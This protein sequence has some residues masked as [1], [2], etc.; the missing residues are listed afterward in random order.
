MH[1]VARMDA[2]IGGDEGESAA[3]GKGVAEPAVALHD[4]KNELRD[5]HRSLVGSV[6]RKTG[7]DHR[8]LMQNSS[9][10]PGAELIRRPSRN[11]YDE[12]H[13]WKSG[14]IR[15]M[16]ERGSESNRMHQRQQAPSLQFNND[17]PFGR[18]LKKSASIRRPLFGLVGVSRL[19]S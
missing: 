6:S 9:S 5:Q 13:C 16:T 2:L 8:R 15:G 19:F 12:S 18:P 1:G 10:G 7:I 11:W 4:K 17:P 3:E 14:E